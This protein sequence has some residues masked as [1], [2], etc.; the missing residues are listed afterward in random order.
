MARLPGWGKNRGRQ[1]ERRKG[2]IKVLRMD[3][4]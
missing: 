2:D 1:R 4:A 3:R